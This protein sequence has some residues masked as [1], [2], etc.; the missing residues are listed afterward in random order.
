MAVGVSLSEAAYA[1]LTNRDDD[2]NAS[3]K[4]GGPSELT[5]P[6][7]DAA[8]APYNH[9][10]IDWWPEGHPPPNVYTVPHLDAHFYFVSQE[11]RESVQPGPAQVYPDERFVPDGYVADSVNVPGDGMHYLNLQAPEFNGEP[12]TH[13]FIYGFYRGTSTFI[14]PMASTDLLSSQPDVTAQVPQP[15]AYQRAGLYPAR[16]RV[17]YNDDAEEHRFVLERLQRHEGSAPGS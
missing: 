6:M 12:F 13:T 4:H 9:A 17:A 10:T 8:P 5:L 2:H 3:A 1:S 11:K 15:E 7:P 16:Y 14:E